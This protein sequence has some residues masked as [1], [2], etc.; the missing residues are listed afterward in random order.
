MAAFLTLSQCKFKFEIT[1]EY[2]K[3]LGVVLSLE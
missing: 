1:C 2:V 3:R